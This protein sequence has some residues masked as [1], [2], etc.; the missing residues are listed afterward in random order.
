MTSCDPVEKGM[1]LDHGNNEEES[2][3]GERSLKGLKVYSYVLLMASARA[4]ME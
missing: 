1:E 3:G 2:G 4:W